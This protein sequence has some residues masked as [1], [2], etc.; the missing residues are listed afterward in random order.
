MK[1]ILIFLMIL[2]LLCGCSQKPQRTDFIEGVHY[3]PALSVEYGGISIETTGGAYSWNYD[4]ED[5]TNTTVEAV[6]ENPF[7]YKGISYFSAGDEKTAKL[8]FGEGFNKC[9]ISRWKVGEDYLEKEFPGYDWADENEEPVEHENGVFEISCDG[10]YIYEIWAWYESGDAYYYFRT[11]A[12]D[13]IGTAMYIKD[14]TST[15]ATVVF[16]QSGGNTTGE[17]MTGRHFNIKDKDGNALKIVPEHAVFTDDAI[18]VPM[19]EVTEIRTDWEWLYGELEPGEYVIYKEVMDF[20]GT[21][22]YD[23]KEYSVKFRVE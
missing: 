2:A 19:G 4:N 10:S 14:V 11:D 3:P 8:V 7:A 1:K 16:K 6:G 23:T 9:F 17:L 12:P 5:G 18:A 20:R 21:G 13:E 22:D 15:G